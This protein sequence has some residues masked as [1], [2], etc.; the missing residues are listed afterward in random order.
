[1]SS[2]A[3]TKVYGTTCASVFAAPP[4]D[5]LTTAMRRSLFTSEHLGSSARHCSQIAE[6]VQNDTAS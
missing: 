5:I 4:N 3:L 1:M 2:A 6:N